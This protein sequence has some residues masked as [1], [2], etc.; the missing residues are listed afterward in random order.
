MIGFYRL[1]KGEKLLIPDELA[2]A[3]EAA[4]TQATQ[5]RQRAEDLAAELAR[6]RDRFGE[7]PES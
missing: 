7:L 4:K 6:Y 5:E 3:L 1:D 2:A